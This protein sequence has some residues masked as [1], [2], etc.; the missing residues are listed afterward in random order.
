M[1]EMA[2]LAGLP[3]LKMN[4]LGN[5]F[6]IVDLRRGKGARMTP[7]SARAIADRK[8]GVG[9]DQVITI[10]DRGGAFMGVWNADGSEVEACGN[11]SRCVGWLLMEETGAANADFAT[12]AGPLSVQRAGERRVT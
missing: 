11:A 5:D 12:L 6:V 8:E 9:C 3:F 4:G 10:E 1:S 2:A 7:A